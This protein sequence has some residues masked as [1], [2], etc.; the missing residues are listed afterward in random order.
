MNKKWLNCQKTDTR[1]MWKMID[2]KGQSQHVP[3]ASL[4]EATVQSFF[5]NIFQSD[6]TLSH[7][8]VL[9]ITE[10]LKKYSCE[11]TTMGSPLTMKEM[12]LVLC[13]VGR[14]IG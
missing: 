3:S 5:K 13:D 4:D 1:K 9:D 12:S 10:D 2:W 14:G 6:K 8:K 11:N 7:P